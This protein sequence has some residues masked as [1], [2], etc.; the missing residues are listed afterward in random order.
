MKIVTLVS[1]LF[2]FSAIAATNDVFLIG[3]SIR[4]G[5]APAVKEKMSGRWNVMFPSENCRFTYYTLRGLYDWVK[6]VPHPEQVEVV[7]WNNGLWDLGQRDRR[8]EPLTPIDVY[9]NTLVRILGEIRHYFPNA[10]VVFAT[11]TPINTRIECEQHTFGNAIVEEY[12]AAAVKELSKR[13][14]VINDLYSF[15]R[16][17]MSPED[18][19]DIVHYTP[20]G[21]AKQADEVIRV[22]SGLL[23]K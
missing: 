11:T 18:Y 6:A 22:I 4:Q 19:R 2:A 16:D 5:Y 10:K 20:A 15:V 1:A 23:V 17:R 3:D 13:G 21:C 7:H 8:P 12:N 14:V 9:T